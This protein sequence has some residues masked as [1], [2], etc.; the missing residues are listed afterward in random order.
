MIFI[1]KV[2][3]KQGDGGTT[4]L[5]TGDEVDKDDLRI[6]TYG[7]TDELNSICGLVRTLAEKDSRLTQLALEL[8]I[9]QNRLFDVGSDLAT[10]VDKRWPNMRIIVDEDITEVEQW[11]DAANEGLGNLTSF[12]LPGGSEINAYLHLCRTVCRRAERC[13]VSLTKQQEI[14]PFALKYL[15]RLSDY[16]FVWSRAVAKILDHPEYLWER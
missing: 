4:R 11:L 7:T 10:P 9:V 5:A 12:T 8:K 14:N 2:Y 15:N 13:C 1:S 16:F 3:T 6:E